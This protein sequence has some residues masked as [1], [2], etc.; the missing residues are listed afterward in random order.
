[1]ARLDY[2]WRQEPSTR[3][4]PLNLTCKCTVPSQANQNSYRTQ[5][6]CDSNKQHLSAY[7]LN[8]K[9]IMEKLGCKAGAE[10]REA[11]WRYHSI[12][13]LQM[14]AWGFNR[15]HMETG[16][17]Q[18]HLFKTRRC[19]LQLWRE[20]T[21]VFDGLAREREW[22]SGWKGLFCFFL[23]AVLIWSRKLERCKGI[24]NKNM[25]AWFRP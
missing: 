16:I 25:A 13:R 18:S 15:I 10:L 4:N 7:N 14:A 3:H 5:K 2:G 24:K 22:W 6:C 21:W 23:K 9:G 8:C 17:Q 1:M 11:V 12:V 19:T 20:C